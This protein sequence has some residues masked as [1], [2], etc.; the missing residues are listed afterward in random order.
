[1]KSTKYQ[2]LLKNKNTK[3][4]FKVQ[5]D[6]IC[7]GDFCRKKLDFWTVKICKNAE[8][9]LPLKLRRIFASLWLGL[10]W[11]ITRQKLIK[12]LISGAVSSALEFWMIS[13]SGS[14]VK[15]LVLSSQSQSLLSSEISS[16]LSGDGI[17]R[18]PSE[19]KLLFRRLRKRRETRELRSIPSRWRSK[20]WERSNSSKLRWLIKEFFFKDYIFF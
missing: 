15:Q 17:A 5:V 7:V 6:H 11:F 10:S 16:K 19:V 3:N 9:I 18:T 12:T 1:M 14:L 13:S 2:N 8:D 20:L 4:N